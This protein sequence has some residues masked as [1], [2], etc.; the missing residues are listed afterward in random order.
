MVPTADDKQALLQDASTPFFTTDHFTG[1]DA[2]LLRP[3]ASGRRRSGTPSGAPA[4]R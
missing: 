4:T 1:Y 3:A 2:V